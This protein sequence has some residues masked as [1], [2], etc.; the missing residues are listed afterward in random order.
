VTLPPLTFITS[1]ENKYNEVVRLLGRPLSRAAPPLDEIQEVALA[2]VVAHKAHH[3]YARIHG[4]VL[5]EDTGL[6]FAAW[7][8]L[9]GALVKWFLSSLGDR[10]VVP[11]FA[12]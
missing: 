7:N 5:V 1:S 9:P 8:G 6:S 2:P 4:P 12:E 10:W 3:A 11:P